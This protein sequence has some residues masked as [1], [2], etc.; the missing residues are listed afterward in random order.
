MTTRRLSDRA[1]IILQH[2]VDRS[3]NGHRWLSGNARGMDDYDKSSGIYL[4]INGSGDASILRGLV[5]L[6]LLERDAPKSDC[7]NQYQ[8]LRATPT[9]IARVELE[10][11]RVTMIR[12]HLIERE[13]QL[14]QRNNA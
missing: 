13:K 4:N 12:N 14:N 8:W 10:S 7:S 1:L 5:R 3:K 2:I 6:G 11:E 9:G